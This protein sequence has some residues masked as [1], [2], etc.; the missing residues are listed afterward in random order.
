MQRVFS[1]YR[2]VTET[3]RAAM[4]ADIAAASIPAVEVFAVQSHFNYRLPQVVRELADALEAHTLRLQSLHAPTE[5]N[6]A[7]G[8]E[9]GVPISLCESERGRR[10]DAVDEMK[11]VLEVAE[12]IPFRVLVVHL[13]HGRQAMDQ[14]RVDAAFSSLEPLAVFA[15]HRGVTIALENTPGELTSP[16]SLAHFIDDTHLHDLK[17]CL[18]TGHAHLED[19]V[20]AS[21]EIMRERLVAMHVHDNRGERD[22]HLLPFEG[23]IN[24]DGFLEKIGGLTLDVPLVMEL[25]EQSP[26]M[27]GPPQAAAA[28]DEIE[29]RLAARTSA[30]SN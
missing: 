7:P 16:S 10:V 28:F 27:P 3:L 22:E 6:L 5:R 29:R 9:S 2:F 18:D 19:G 4:L 25:K 8:R 30:A 24:W 11:R 14:R 21:F 23:T 15:K 17:L 1:T 12:A 26:G 13:G 20:E